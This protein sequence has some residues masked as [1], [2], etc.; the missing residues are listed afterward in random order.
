MAEN[1]TEN[2]ISKINTSEYKI[3]SIQQTLVRNFFPIHF[4]PNLDGIGMNDQITKYRKTEGKA[5]KKRE[6]SSPKFCFFCVPSPDL[7]PS[8]NYCFLML[9]FGRQ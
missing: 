8:S 9:H 3:E 6:K 4:S 1:S 2:K 7:Q 5:F